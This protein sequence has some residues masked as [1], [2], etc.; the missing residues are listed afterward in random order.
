MFETLRN[1]TEITPLLIFL[2]FLLVVGSVGLWYVKKTTGRPMRDLLVVLV[3][4]FVL[5]ILFTPIIVL[6][7]REPWR[8]HPSIVS[9]LVFSAL[10][11]LVW[12]AFNKL[13][14]RRSKR[15]RSHKDHPR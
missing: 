13:A 9:Y 4:G 10:A 14:R 6:E 5:V 1:Y 8:R 7:S 12:W 11:L 2:G 3:A 15:A